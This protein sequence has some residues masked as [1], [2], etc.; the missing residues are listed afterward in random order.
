[1]MIGPGGE[2]AASV[3]AVAGVDGGVS[4]PNCFCCKRDGQEFVCEN[5]SSINSSLSLSLPLVRGSE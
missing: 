1:M 2:E 3:L 5:L 4:I